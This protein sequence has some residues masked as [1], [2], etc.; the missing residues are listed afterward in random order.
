MNAMKT[1]ERDVAEFLEGKARIGDPIHYIDVVNRF[2]D[3]G[4]LTSYWS[5]HP[6]SAIFGHLDDEDETLKR[7]YRTALVISTEHRMPGQ[8]FFDT[9]A[10][11]RKMTILKADKEELWIRELNAL[12]AYYRNH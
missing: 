5:G 2:P 12:I 7:P 6:L 1:T 3:L 8:G 9:M 4:H 10:A 11:L